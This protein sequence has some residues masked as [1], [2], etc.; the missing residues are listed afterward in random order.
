MPK[1]K[2]PVEQGEPVVIE[3]ADE[4][5]GPERVA[6][7][8]AA[9][10]TANETVATVQPDAAGQPPGAVVAEDAPPTGPGEQ[11]VAESQA[12]G[13]QRETDVATPAAGPGAAA[14]VDPNAVT[15]PDQAAADAGLS[16]EEAQTAPVN[17]AT[18]NES[19]KLPGNVTSSAAKAHA[20][21][22]QAQDAGRDGEAAPEDRLDRVL[23][24]V[25][26]ALDELDKFL[27]DHVRAPAQA[28]AQ[29]A[30]E[31]L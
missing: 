24:I 26:L 21:L 20:M 17:P 9:E 5:G 15:P 14:S 31:R 1:S 10:G 8:P 13:Q 19:P 11:S 25:S 16:P 23:S 4:A 27:P 28:E 7:E 12:A 6:D 2:D 3:P 29:Q 30:V 22:S 18:S